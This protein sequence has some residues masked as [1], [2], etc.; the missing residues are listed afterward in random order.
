L[1][2][3]DYDV[4]SSSTVSTLQQKIRDRFLISDCYLFWDITN[5]N[6]AIYDRTVLTC[7]GLL[8][9]KTSRVILLDDTDWGTVPAFD[10]Y[11]SALP[12]IAATYCVSTFSSLYAYRVIPLPIL[13]S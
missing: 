13:S 2:C 5:G 10:G 7:G 4:S 3:G 8:N 6:R 11:I 9:I 12:S 1:I